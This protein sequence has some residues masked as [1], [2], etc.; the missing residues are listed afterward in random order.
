MEGRS[1]VTATSQYVPIIVH[2]HQQ[3]NER[4]ITNSI[5]TLQD[6]RKIAI[7]VVTLA[8]RTCCIIR[9]LGPLYVQTVIRTNTTLIEWSLI[10]GRDMVVTWP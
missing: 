5:I 1:N 9:T 6:S 4:V 7:T 10:N 8:W 2:S 3:L